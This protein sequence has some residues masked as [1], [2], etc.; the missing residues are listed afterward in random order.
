MLA[1]LCLVAACLGVAPESKAGAT[2]QVRY[3]PGAKIRIDGRSDEP[4]WAKANAEKGFRFPWSDAPPPA[5]DF[6]ALVDD[7]SL[8]FTFR[9]QDDDIVVLDKLRD[10]Q[11]AVFEDRGEVILSLDAKMSDYFCLE[12]DSRGRTYDYRAHYYRRFEPKWSMKGLETAGSEVPKGYVV[13]GRIPLDTLVELG[14]PRLKPG[15]KIR[16]GLFRAE[17][18]HDRSARPAKPRA[19]IHNAGR[20]PPGVPP[21]EGWMSWVEPKTK[22]PDFHVPSSLGWLEVVR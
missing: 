7:A 5:T 22:E 12:V 1:S 16:C 14:F 19:T 3:M 17:F 11:D 9:M 20:Q 13:E 15:E 10:K 6:R 18:S 4:D 8:Y 2:Y 21:I